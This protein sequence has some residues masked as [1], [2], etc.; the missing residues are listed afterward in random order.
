MSR[1]PARGMVLGH[2]LLCLAA[3][4]AVLSNAVADEQRVPEGARSQAADRAELYPPSLRTNNRTLDRAFQIALGDLLGNIMP[5]QN[6]L[7]TEPRLAI[8]A[9]LDYGRPWTRDS[10]INAW[11]GASLVVPQ[12]ARDTLLSVLVREGETVRIGGQYWDAVVWSTGAW[13]HYLYTHDRSFLELALE[14]TRN[15]LAYFERTEFDAQKGLFRGPGWSDGVAAYPVEFATPTGAILDWPKLNPQN[16]SK[17]GYGIPMQAISTN[18]LYYNAYVLAGKMAQELD[19]PADPAWAQKATALRK[20]VNRHLW[21]EPAGCYRFFVGPFGDCNHQEALGHAYAILFNVADAR[22]VD[23]IFA[24]QHVTPAGVPCVWPS[25]PRYE[26]S[27]GTSFGRHAG[28]VWPQIQ[29]FWAT[30]AARQ[31]RAA[32]FGHELFNLAKNAERDMHFAEIYHPDSGRPYGGMQE[33]ADRGIILWKAT[34][35]QTWAATA[36]IRMVLLGLAGMRFETDGLR[37]LPCIPATIDQVELRNVKYG[38]MR[39]DLTLRGSGKKIVQCSV[40]G[41]PVDDPFLRWEDEGRKEIV[42]TMGD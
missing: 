18:C 41:R 26:N 4:F 16:A 33:S 32:V 27:Q 37:I 2:Y 1:M 30:A 11:N 34:S 5:H 42:I 9:G 24:N 14:A 6:G 19:V 21:N 29:G 31:G 15:S 36:Y 23:A 12:V 20:A 7:L 22:Q 28:T 3:T 35:R 25:F 10:A 39:L 38:R 40:N 17:P 8:H 13:N